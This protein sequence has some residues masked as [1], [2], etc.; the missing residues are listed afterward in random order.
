MVRKHFSIIAQSLVLITVVSL[1]GCIDNP[2]VVYDANKPKPGD[3][4]EKIV[5]HKTGGFAGVSQII[6]I[7]EK[8][9][10]ILLVSVDE[11]ANKRVESPVSP[12]DLDSLWQT[13]EH[14]DVF[15]LPT[16]QKMLETVMDGF[17]FEITVQRNEKQNQ[18][19]VYAP[20]LLIESGETRYSAITQ[21]I[22][23]LADSRQDT[24]KFIIA[25]MPIKDI[26]VNI[27]E[28]FPYQI[29][30]VVNGFL[31]D[32]CT[33]LNEITQQRNENT[34]HIHITTKRPKD[35]SCIQV[36]EEVTERIPVEGG[37]LPGHYRVIVNEVGEEFDI[38]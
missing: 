5:M 7:E 6:T 21:A 12:E 8:D 15:T 24:E 23:Q 37:F 10:S 1:I 16:N 20:E 17:F 22:E 29:N 3:A 33:T 13:L 18:F 34:I 4:T 31:R 27:L 32:G 25:D 11:R 30:V 9:G 35:K 19:S 26:S 2:L 38:D 28:S 36:I 14:N